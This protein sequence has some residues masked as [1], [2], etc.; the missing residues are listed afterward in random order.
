MKPAMICLLPLLSLLWT[1]E[2]RAQHGG[3]ELQYHAITSGN[4][5]ADKNFYLLTVLEHHEMIRKFLAIDPALV[6]FCHRGVGRGGTLANAEPG[7]PLGQFRQYLYSTQDSLTVDSALARLY[8]AHRAAFDLMINQHLRAS[9]YLQ[10][11]SGET[12]RNLLLKAWGQVVICHNTIVRHFG[13]EN[14]WYELSADSTHAAYRKQAS[15][16]LEKATKMKGAVFY[17]PFLYVALGLMRADDRDEPVRHEPLPVTLNAAVLRKIPGTQWKSYRYSAILLL[18]SGPAVADEA[19]S[20][21]GRVRADSAA[22]CYNKRLAPFIIVS[23]GYVHPDHTRFSEAVE[24]KRY[25]VAHHHIPASAIITEPYARH[26]TTNIRNANR[27]IYRYHILVS[28]PVLVVSSPF[29]IAIITSAD[30]SFD[31]RNLRE[32]GYL[33]YKQMVLVSPSEASYFPEI[34]SLQINP[35]DPLDP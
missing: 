9:G 22:W 28:K 3:F 33:P 13:I 19:L 30:H 18:G 1:S 5:V 6:K 35:S 14:K 25:L 20:A 11:F 8:V 26:T 17:R 7:W 24:M 31:N 16:V 10:L 15:E 32:L 23:G 21:V 2:L 12:N 4:L 27:L 34:T 29:H